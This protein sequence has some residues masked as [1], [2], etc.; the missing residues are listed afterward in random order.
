MCAQ[1]DVDDTPLRRDYD[2]WLAMC[3]IDAI[4]ALLLG[5]S[6]SSSFRCTG[7]SSLC[8]G[9]TRTSMVFDGNG[10]QI[11]ADIHAHGLPQAQWEAELKAMP[12]KRGER[13]R[14]ACGTGCRHTSL[15]IDRSISGLSSLRS[16]PPTGRRR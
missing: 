4:V 1:M 15:G 10:R 16:A 7:R 9:S 12:A 13:S 14:W 11:S 8:F 5:L 2:R 6:E 3:E